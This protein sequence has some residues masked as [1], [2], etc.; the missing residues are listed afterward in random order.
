MDFTSKQIDFRQSQPCIIIGEVGVN[1]NNDRKILFQLIDAGIEAGLDIIKFQRFKAGDEISTY[2]PKAQYQLD[3]SNDTESQLD[4]ARK[5]ELSDPLLVE[6]YEYCK[7][8]GVG[9]LCAAFDNESVDFIADSVIK[10]MN[11][12]SKIEYTGGEIGWVGDVPRFEYD[13]TKMKTLGWA[14][15]FTSDEA[16]QKTISK[17]LEE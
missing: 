13:T 2:A 6:A 9:F 15:K 12:G 17:L 3:L 7:E 10:Q 8:K 4:M 14:L 1:H 5:L 11:L 16:V